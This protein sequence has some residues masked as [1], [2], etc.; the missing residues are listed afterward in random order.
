MGLSRRLG[1]S[2]LDVCVLGGWM[3]RI[4]DLGDFGY[5]RKEVSLGFV[6]RWVFWGLVFFG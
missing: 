1:R 3:W 6:F 2:R 4:R 5:G